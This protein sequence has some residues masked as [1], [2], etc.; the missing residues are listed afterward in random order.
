MNGE[1]V[2]HRACECK[3]ADVARLLLQAGARTDARSGAGDTAM[4]CAARAGLEELTSHLLELEKKSGSQTDLAINASNLSGETPLH[5]GHLRA[6]TQATEAGAIIM[7]PVPAFY[8]RPKN[9]DDMV[10][11]TVA[12]ALDL[13]GIDSDL[14]R[15]W[16]E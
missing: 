13:L 4:H 8:T 12:R 2:I 1:G 9:L 10:T 14:V 16:G 5:L 11:Q 7:P 3:K 6:M 15:R